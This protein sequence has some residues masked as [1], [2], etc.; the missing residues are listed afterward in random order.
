MLFQRFPH[1][2]PVLRGRLHDDFLDLVLD[3]PVG[4]ATQIGR[5]R[6]DLLTHEVEVA[7]DLDVGHHDRQHL[8]VDVNSRDL[9]RHRS[10]LGSGE[11]ASSH[12]SGSRAIE[13]ELTRA[14]T[15]LNYSLNHAH[16][17][18][19]SWSASTAPL[20]GS[21]SPPPPA[22]WLAPIFIVFHGPRAHINSCGNHP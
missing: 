19:H 8:L 7:V 3:Q 11:R 18:P 1:R 5:R 20:V 12:Q 2:P 17:G 14:H 10:L 13:E 21:I 15:M 4:Q 6:A 9:V 22:L 16:S